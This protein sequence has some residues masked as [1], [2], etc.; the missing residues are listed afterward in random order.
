M[1]LAQALSTHRKELNKKRQHRYK[2][3]EEDNSLKELDSILAYGGEC[4]VQVELDG[5]KKA[6]RVSVDTGQRLT[7]NVP[8]YKWHIQTAMGYRMF[9]KTKLRQHAQ[10]TINQLLG[11]GMYTVCGS[12]V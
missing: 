11:K 10:Q 6:V 9:I 12:D 8:K 5:R 1:S 7:K 2:K 4:V 3:V